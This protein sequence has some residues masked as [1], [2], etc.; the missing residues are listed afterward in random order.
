[1]LIWKFKAKFANLLGIAMQNQLETIV[2]EPRRVVSAGGVIYRIING[3]FDVALICV[4]GIWCLPKG[5]IEQ[6]ER[7]EETAL[8]EV[9]EETGL[10]GELIMRIDDINYSFVKK[11]KYFKTVHFYLVKQ[12][13][14]SL[15]EH[16]TEVDKAQ[17]FP[18]SE[19]Y[20]ILVYPNERRILEKAEKMLRG[21]SIL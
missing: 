19:A 12:T 2:L 15:A 3:H 7:P 6:D 18:I 14:G 4:G 10:E 21:G 1:L 16:D 20:Q 13:G 8:R 17:W 9:R 11:T 5:L